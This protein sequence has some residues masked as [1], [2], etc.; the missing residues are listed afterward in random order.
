MQKINTA[1][2]K[3]FLTSLA[4]KIAGDKSYRY[5]I[6]YGSEE[7]AKRAQ[8]KYYRA[9]YALMKNDP[10]FKEITIGTRGKILYFCHRLYYTHPRAKPLYAES[11]KE[12]KMEGVPSFVEPL[13]TPA[14]S[15][16]GEGEKY[17][18]SF[19]PYAPLTPEQEETLKE[20]QENP[21]KVYEE[22]IAK[23]K[24]EEGEK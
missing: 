16:I 15:P 19:D 10:F 13:Q 12:V 21:D 2:A 14:E 20:I 11:I 1:N 17:I 24:G 22:I 9:K 3:L 8:K 7:L 5:E 23:L 4:T 6:E 18:P